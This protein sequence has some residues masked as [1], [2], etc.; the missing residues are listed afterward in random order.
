MKDIRSLN[1]NELKELMVSLNEKPFR[2]A[3]IFEWLHVKLASDYEEM[4]NISLGLRNRLKE[5][6][7][8]NSLEIV[9]VLKDEEDGTCKFLFKTRDNNV[10]S[11]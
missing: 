5:E 9:R 4:T 3:Q 11:S 6:Y 7:A 8:L 2:A 10:I 1:L